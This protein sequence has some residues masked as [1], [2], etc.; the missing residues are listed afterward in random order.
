[1]CYKCMLLG[2]AMRSS[3]FDLDRLRGGDFFFMEQPSKYLVD[4]TA[5][6]Y[7]KDTLS[8]LEQA[9]CCML[10]VKVDGDGN[11]LVHAISRAI[12]GTEI[13]YSVLRQKMF[14]ELRDHKLFYKSV[15]GE[16]WVEEGNDG[17]E[18]ELA[19]SMPTSRS[20]SWLSPLHIFALSNVLRRPII[21]FDKADK[22]GAVGQNACGMYLPL[23][24]S[25]EE[26]RLSVSTNEMPAPLAIAW[27][28]G[29]LNHY[30]CLS[31][32]SLSSPRA[33]T[34]KS[35]LS[36]VRRALVL[37]RKSVAGDLNL[38][39]QCLEFLLEIVSA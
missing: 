22:I 34:I 25:P 29:S 39:R 26:C 17:F 13:F 4:S 10:P 1:M 7:L 27:S 3:C 9:G 20:V 21:L 15:M 11:C 36:G 18:G 24:F 23:R 35:P 5:Q 28:S 8:L 14:R 32:V 6:A 19:R 12:G 2:A 31:H 16:A 38:Y 37:L 33:N 30:V